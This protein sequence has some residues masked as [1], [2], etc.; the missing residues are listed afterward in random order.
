[1]A[2]QE[3][4]KPFTS[5]GW[6]ELAT[7]RD[8]RKAAASLGAE[9]GLGAARVHMELAYTYRQ[10]ALLSAQSL[11]Q[12]YA[13]TPDV[14]DPVGVA[15]LLSV[16]YAITG[17]LDKAREQSAKLEGLAEDPTA[18]WHGPWKAWLAG[19]AAWPP[20]LSSLPLALGE[21]EAGRTP[22]LDGLP[23]YSLPE[24]SESKRLR[25]MA[26]PGALVALALWHDAA[27]GHPDL[28]HRARAG[29]RLPVEGPVVA[30]DGLFP[31]EMLFASDHGVPADVDFLVDVHG[32]AGMA[33]VDKW[34]DRSIVAALA[35]GS[36]VDGK[37]DVERAID[38]AAAAHAQIVGAASARTA[39]TVQGHQRTFGKML[40]VGTLRNLALVAEVEGDREV[41]GRLRINALELSGK[42]TACPVGMLALGA[43]DASNRYPTRAQDIL[44]DLSRRFPSLEA[45]RYGL[46]VMALRVSRERTGETPGM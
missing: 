45:A 29:Y 22:H 24:Q 20:D 27:A 2:T 33:A 10:A 32:A 25:E 42:S 7:R 8:Y 23:H 3:D 18:S 12:T 19:D 11:I 31:F 40:H 4:F 37:M 36:M 5:P 35:K 41:S 39:D 38:L 43:W 26:D 6:V 44:H 16:S 34:A 21:V 30:G 14:T 9:G 46:D 28:I 1:M 17:N 15:H 13:E